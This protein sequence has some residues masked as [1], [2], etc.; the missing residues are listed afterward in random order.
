MAV[1]RFTEANEANEGQVNTVL[2]Q[3]VWSKFSPMRAAGPAAR[4]ALAF[5]ELLAHPLDMLSSCFGLFHGDGPADPF[6][7]R[8]RRDVFPGSERGLVGG[9]SF[10]Q[11]RRDFVYHAAGDCFFRH[12]A[13]IQMHN[14]DP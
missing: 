7:A 4:P 12:I 11:I 3:T 2:K 10:P 9:K 14:F 13:P 6:I 5:F 1:V 8:E